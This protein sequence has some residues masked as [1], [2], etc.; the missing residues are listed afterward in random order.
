[1][2]NGGAHVRI[3]EDLSMHSKLRN[4]FLAA[5]A[6]AVAVFLLLSGLGDHPL[7]DPDEGRYAQPP[8]EMFASGDF[9]LP[10]LNGEPRLKK[11]PG[12]YWAVAASYLALGPTEFA[13]RLPSVASALACVLAVLVMGWKGYSPLTGALSAVVLA[14]AVLFGAVARVCIT[15][16]TL[17]ATITGA[18]A[19]YWWTTRSEKKRPVV[20]VVIWFLVVASVMV[21][22]PV[23]LLVIALVALVYALAS[24]DITLFTRVKPLACLFIVVAVAVPWALWAALSETVATKHW[25]EESLA[26]FFGGFRH[27][28]PVWFYIPVVLAGFGFWSAFFPVPGI[29]LRWAE[30]K[31]LFRPRS[32]NL[33]LLVWAGVTFAFFSIS[34]SKLYT[35]ILPMFPPMAI[36]LGRTID[37]LLTGPPRMLRRVFCGVALL[38]LVAGMTGGLIIFAPK[39][40]LAG[41]TGWMKAGTALALVT[42]AAIVL[43]AGRMRSAV[44]VLIAGIVVFMAWVGPAV[45]QHY[46]T[47]NSAREMAAQVRRAHGDDVKLA[48]YGSMIPTL[49]FYWGEHMERPKSS[50]QLLEFF[51]KNPS[52]VCL[53]RKRKN[54]EKFEPELKEA[55]RVQGE[56]GWGGITVLAVRME[57]PMPALRSGG[58][59]DE[60]QDELETD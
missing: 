9:L 41:A 20:T 39:V 60:I 10:T 14:S 49:R 11:P 18:V 42:V 6:A 26:H 29:Q 7:I 8:R 38:V 54:F 46:A 23:G 47:N 34:A 30:L 24:R 27:R 33:F 52:G 22:G 35:Y 45:E 19:L 5:G 58:T 56:Y 16:M 55:I 48:L 32:M 4:L 21:K 28:E 15:D 50:G 44:W 53:I 3:G 43:L 37:R 17:T 51:E 31:G 1:L 59:G 57:G 12:F 40:G 25:Y 13:A 36:V 2:C